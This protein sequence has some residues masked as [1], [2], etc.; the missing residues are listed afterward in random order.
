MNLNNGLAKGIVQK[1]VLDTLTGRQEDLAR[2]M[3]LAAS[4]KGPKITAFVRGFANGD[5]TESGFARLFLRVGSQ[6]N[7]ECKKKLVRNLVCNWGIDGT[8]KRKDLE[9]RGTHA[10]S[11]IVISP[12]MRCNLRC[13][14]CYSGLYEKDGD[15]SEAELDRVLSEARSFGAYFVV[16]SGG[17]PY[18]MKEVWLRLFRK[19]NDMYFMTYTNG[20]LLDQA[21]VDELARLGNVAPAISVEGY[22]AET[23]ARRGEGTFDRVL[24]AMERLRGAGIVFGM[25]VTYTSGNIDLVTGEDFMRYFIDKGALFAW[26]FMFMPVGKDPMLSLV[27][28]PEQRAACGQRIAE[29]RSRVPLFLADFWN[30]GPSVGGCLAGGRQYLHILNSGRVEPCVF[31]HFGMDSIREK[32]VL[33]AAN[34]PFFKSI[35]SRF[36]YNGNANLKRPC[37]IIDNPRVLRDAVARHLAPAG[38]VHSEDII[39]DP[40]T[41]KWV[42]EY[43]ARFKGIVDPLWEAEI[44]RPDGRW[45]RGGEE[46]RSLFTPH[47]RFGELNPA[48]GRKA[49]ES[50]DT[51][52]EPV[53]I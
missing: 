34:S 17:E 24:A 3:R 46:Y 35:R 7:P 45:Y 38:H 47:N 28:S 9:R 29:M 2:V 14:G 26:F 37:M 48:R 5:Y 12:S 52:A 32:T 33:E 15:L 23:D 36:P 25:S 53:H 44:S 1:V 22:R 11:F 39:N 21:A 42:D 4:I 10:P 27:P 49:A 20:T 40:K 6:A 16:V 43:A 19:Y 8:N 41:V 50:P 13:T 18:V 51:Q 31:A 30:D